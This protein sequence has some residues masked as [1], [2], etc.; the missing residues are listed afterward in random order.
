MLLSYLKILCLQIARIFVTSL[1]KT[2]IELVSRLS[3]SRSTD[4]IVDIN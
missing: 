1:V 2:I 3:R 4:V